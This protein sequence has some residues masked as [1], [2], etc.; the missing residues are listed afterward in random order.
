METPLFVPNARPTLGVELEFALVDADTMALTS[1][2][3]TVVSGLP[4]TVRPSVKPE[5][6]QCY[7]EINSGICDTVDDVAADLAPKIEAVRGSAREAGVEVLW[8]ATHPFSPWAEQ[9]ITRNDR[10]FGLVERL[11]DTARRLVTF[12]L[13]VH[14]GLDSGDKAVMITDR[15]LRHLP[16]L[17]A[18]S[19]NSP[20]WNGRDTGLQSQRSKVMADLPTA[21]LP[22]LMRNWSE[23]VWLLRHMVETGFVQ[24]IREVWW[25]VR[26]HH[27]FGTIEVRICDMPRDLPTVLSLTALIQCL[28][29]TLSAEIDRGTYQ[30]D[31]HPIMVRLNKWRACRHGL[32]AVLVDPY[33]QEARPAADVIGRLSESLRETAIE[34]GCE[35]HLARLPELV[36]RGTGAEHQRR[37]AADCR[38]DLSQVVRRLLAEPYS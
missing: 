14:V 24:T 27:N 23:Y 22:P 32:A 16:A 36:R 34:L 29:H 19:A 2:Y 5:L 18:L 20:F 12:G 6:M 4:D 15:L 11:Q 13:H 21:G 3:D 35:P 28:V 8:A 33:T 17:L 26:P 38:G 31:C 7:L 1:A 37:L 9:K 25:D 10:Y 30:Y